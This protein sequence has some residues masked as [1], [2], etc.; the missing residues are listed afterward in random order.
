MYLKYIHLSS[1]IL[2]NFDTKWDFA[3]NSQKIKG[4]N[5]FSKQ[6]KT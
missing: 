5:T 6:I 3:D 2:K 4:E 1:I